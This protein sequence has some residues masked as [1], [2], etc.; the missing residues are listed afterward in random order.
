MEAYLQSNYNNN[1]NN[2]NNNM[3]LPLFILNALEL[4]GAVDDSTDDMP[5]PRG[6]D[7]VELKPDTMYW[8]RRIVSAVGYKWLIGVPSSLCLYDDTGIPDMESYI[9]GPIYR[10]HTT[11]VHGDVFSVGQ[12]NLPQVSNWCATVCEGDYS[13]VMGQDI[14]TEDPSLEPIV[15]AN[16]AA[17]LQTYFQPLLDVCESLQSL[18]LLLQGD[19]LDR[20]C[21]CLPA[22]LRT[23]YLFSFSADKGIEYNTVLV[24]TNEPDNK[25][26]S[27]RHL[28]V[29]DLCM[30]WTSATTETAD[31]FA[32]G[33]RCVVAKNYHEFQSM[34]D[35]RIIDPSSD[36]LRLVKY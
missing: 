31:V 20:V 1:N 26:K 12:R 33:L 6:L 13:S 22:T 29:Q 24:R 3:H 8:I 28:F 16:Y 34:V 21:L 25:L 11:D 10:L 35:N 19:V 15:R 2:S 18:D 30:V 36:H 5:I 23:L 27:L 9:V 14:D 4:Y 17:Y 7:Y 32:P